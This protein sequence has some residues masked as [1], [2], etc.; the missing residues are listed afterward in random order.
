MTQDNENKHRDDVS[1]VCPDRRPN[2]LVNNR[3]KRRDITSNLRSD[4]E[5]YACQTDG[6]IAGQL[7]SRDIGVNR[8][9]FNGKLMK[10]YLVEC[11]QCLTINFSIDGYYEIGLR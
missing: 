4:R 5:V 8:K 10:N 1:I 2:P 11:V 7:Q 3:G 9:T 6:S